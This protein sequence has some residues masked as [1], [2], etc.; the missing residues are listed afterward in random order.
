MLSRLDVPAAETIYGGDNLV[1]D[2]QGAVGAGIWPVLLRHRDIKRSR[3]LPEVGNLVWIESL[4]PL[5]A[6]VPTD[7]IITIQQKLSEGLESA[8]PII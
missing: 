6:L 5:C 1:T 4:E 8:S 2:I 3:P 7:S